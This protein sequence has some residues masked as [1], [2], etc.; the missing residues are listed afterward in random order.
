MSYQI[1]IDCINLRP[2]PRLAHTEYCSNDALRR[3]IRARQEME[4]RPVR[5]LEEDWEC[6]L[7]WSVN[8]GEGWDKRGR[9]TD[10]GHA[11]FLE[12]GVDRREPTPSPFK[13]VEE[14]W[15]FD[16]LKEY[17]APEMGGLVAQMENWWQAAQKANPTQVV[18]TGYYKTLIS[19][20]I[21]AFGWDLLLEAAAEQDKF[22]RVIDG[23]SNLTMHYVKAHAQT[24][25]PV[26]IQHDDMVWTAGP[27]MHPDFYRRVL[28]PR[29]REF[30]KVLHDA[31]KKVLYCSD[32]DFTM[33]V[34]DIIAAGAD[35]LIF[36]PCV[37]LDH[38]VSRCG[39][40]HAIVGS[41]VDCRTLTFGTKDQ[42]AV[43]ID[44]TLKIAMDCPGFMFAVGNHIPSNVP[45]ENAL[46]Y[47]DYLSKRWKR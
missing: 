32:G 19:G 41:K 35:G 6:D 1:G 5:S 18:T 7:V 43:E 38:V 34:D 24:S 17:G 47:Y 37:S 31:G 29:Y 10:M 33:F 3:T 36:E 4:G 27:F 42:I 12:G 25:A 21:Q 44:A 9:Q 2:T 15:A 13:D 30:W 8:D 40:T 23:F 14:V 46:F 20:A 16:A 11:D 22:E 39:K 45:L 28:F 26:F